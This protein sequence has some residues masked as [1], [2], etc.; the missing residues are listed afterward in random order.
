[1]RTVRFYCQTIDPLSLLDSVESHHLSRVLR[2]PVGAAVELFDGQGTLAEGVVENITRQQVTIRTG[3]TE[4]NTPRQ[5]GRI[6][7]AVSFAKGQRFDWLVEKCTELGVDH[8]AAVQFERTVKLGKAS[9]LQRLEKITLS[10]AKQSGRLFLPDLTGPD[11]LKATVESLQ[12]RYP[13]CQFIYGDPDATIC[14]DSVPRPAPLDTVI[15]IGPEG[16]FTTSE[17]NYLN[18]LNALP[19]RINDNVLRV[20]T[21]ATAFCSLLAHQRM[22]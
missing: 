4:H 12:S 19:V 14:P 17:T 7:L 9:S 18:S 11:K 10:A 3:R 6:I 5:Q 16:G 15:L 2:L 20:E 8:I 22:L 13:T 1:M 21:A